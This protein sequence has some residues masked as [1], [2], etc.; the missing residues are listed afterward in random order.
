MSVKVGAQ[1]GSSLHITAI[2]YYFALTQARRRRNLFE[3]RR[4][5]VGILQHDRLKGNLRRRHGLNRAVGVEDI[6]A[7]V[8]T[9]G[10]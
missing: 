9:L 4:R 8:S 10:S 3:A 6:R 1:W 7:A 2:K 5:T